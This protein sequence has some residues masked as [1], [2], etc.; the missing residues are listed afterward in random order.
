MKANRKTSTQKRLLVTI[1]QTGMLNFQRTYLGGSAEPEI[2]ENSTKETKGTQGK[3]NLRMK[4][5]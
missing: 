5:T 3:N 2:N 1:D 4:D